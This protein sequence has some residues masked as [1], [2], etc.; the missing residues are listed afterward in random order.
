LSAEM[1][2]RDGVEEVSGGDRRLGLVADSIG[3]GRE[4]PPGIKQ[5]GERAAD[6]VLCGAVAVGSPTSYLSA[7]AGSNA[8]LEGC[9]SGSVVH[10]GCHITCC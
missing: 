1:G 4:D 5:F 9:A 8:G 6:D 10:A 2:D 7:C 3:A